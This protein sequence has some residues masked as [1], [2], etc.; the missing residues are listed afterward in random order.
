[1]TYL[2]KN[3]NPKNVNMISCCST[4]ASYSPGN[5]TFTYPLNSI[6][7]SSNSNVTINTST[8]EINLSDKRYFC[9]F[10]LYGGTSGSSFTIRCK[11]L[12]NGNEVQNISSYDDGLANTTGHTA[13]DFTIADISANQNDKLKV[14]L[15]STGASSNI[16]YGKSNTDACT[17]LYMLE[18][19]K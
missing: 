4:T 16:Y 10:K 12:L 11:I 13:L 17:F 18:Y 19:D 14:T 6:I 1:M 3:P 8:Y 9:I 5:G 15:T 2:I 7:K